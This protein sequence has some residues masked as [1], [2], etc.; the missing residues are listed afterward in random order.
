MFDKPEL[1]DEYMVKLGN[2]TLL[3]KTINASVSN[4]P[5]QKKAPGYRHSSFLL[6]KSIAEEPK[7]G[8]NT[9]LNRAVAELVTFDTWNSETIETRQEMLTRLAHGTWGIPKAVQGLS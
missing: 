7:V 9:Q 5:F 8:V 4:E 2:L 1:Y 6:T 3:E